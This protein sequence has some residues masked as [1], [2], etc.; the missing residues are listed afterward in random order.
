MK[1]EMGNLLEK[2]DGNCRKKKRKSSSYVT[3]S[4]AFLGQHKEGTSQACKCK[5][6]HLSKF[7]EE[8]KMKPVR[9]TEASVL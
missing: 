3:F 4:H 8:V 5:K 9:F 1:G 7:E 6:M 2:K